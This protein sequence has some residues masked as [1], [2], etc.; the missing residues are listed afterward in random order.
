MATTL[1]TVKTDD[2]SNSGYI[3]WPQ[4]KDC[5]KSTLFKNRH[6]VCRNLENKFASLT[7]IEKSG[8]LVVKPSHAILRKLSIPNFPDK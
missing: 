3:V 8:V 4:L 6:I 7:K 5:H 2:F 1:F